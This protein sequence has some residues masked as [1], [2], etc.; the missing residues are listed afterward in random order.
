MKALRIRMTL[1][2]IKPKIYR[3]VIVPQSWTLADLH[4]ALCSV[5]GWRGRGREEFCAAED[6]YTRLPR[7]STLEYEAYSTTLS[8]T[9]LLDAL[10]PLRKILWRYDYEDDWECLL[11]LESSSEWEGGGGLPACV[12]GARASPPEDIGG[13]DEY[14]RFCRAMAKA[15]HW[16][17]ARVV[18]LH[19]GVFDTNHF[20]SS[21]A[22]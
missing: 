14:R 22:F 15:T 8:T 12:D 7:Q 16:D 4:G 2:W 10:G 11:E 6:L 17:H 5:M 21:L 18:A 13:P 19:G 3:V 20:D 1:C 9:T